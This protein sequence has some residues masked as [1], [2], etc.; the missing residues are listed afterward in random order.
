MEYKDSRE[1]RMKTKGTKKARSCT[2][3]EEHHVTWNPGSRYW[4]FS[5]KFLSAL[6]EQNEPRECLRV[7]CSLHAPSGCIKATRP[8]IKLSGACNWPANRQSG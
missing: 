7:L 5:D 3:R 1:D 4:I 6:N 2:S 8:V